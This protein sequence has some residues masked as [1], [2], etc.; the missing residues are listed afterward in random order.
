MDAKAPGAAWLMRVDGD[1]VEWLSRRLSTPEQSAATRIH[2]P[3]RRAEYAASRALAKVAYIDA[4]GAAGA[5][6]RWRFI[7][8]GGLRRMSASLAL[9]DYAVVGSGVQSGPPVL[10]DI[11]RQHC[12]FGISI[13]HRWPFVATNYQFG[14]ACGI[15]VERVTSFAPGFEDR[16][17]GDAAAFAAQLRQLER[18][19]RLTFWWTMKEAA[20]KAFRPVRGSYGLDELH[21]TDFTNE[22]QTPDGTRLAATASIQLGRRVAAASVASTAFERVICTEVRM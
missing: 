22:Q 14:G 12:E 8:S 4:Q 19:E 5:Q 21:I 6:E 3:R 10:L 11:G 1:D 15:D 18:R 2:S 16:Y 13:A 17:L 7:E 9:A 20:Y